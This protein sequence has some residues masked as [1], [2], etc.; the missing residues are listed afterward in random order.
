MFVQVVLASQ[1]SIAPV[2][3]LHPTHFNIV[4]KHDAAQQLSADDATVIHVAD[5]WSPAKQRSEAAAAAAGGGGATPAVDAGSSRP[6]GVR[7]DVQLRQGDSTLHV[8]A[9]ARVVTHPRPPS[10]TTAQATA[11]ALQEALLAVQQQLAAVGC[12]WLDAC[13][14]HLYLR[15]MSH[16]GAANAA[17]CKVLPAVGPP[18]RACVQVGGWGL[19]GA[20]ARRLEQVKV[21]HTAACLHICQM[22]SMARPCWHNPNSIVF[23][24]VLCLSTQADLPE[25][26]PVLLDVLVH[27]QSAVQQA[28]PTTSA[29]AAAGSRTGADGARASSLGSR[30]VLHVQSISDWA[31][32]CIGPYSQVSPDIDADYMIR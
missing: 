25:D 32:S 17:Y 21:V 5:D 19:E 28:T 31:P 14:V 4:S 24:G 11:A 7:V 16:F 12:T 8:T 23:L 26:T 6:E 2:G 20:R 22:A 9:A 13:F 27:P 30:R 1:D 10:S 3:L 29:A 18:A 15:D